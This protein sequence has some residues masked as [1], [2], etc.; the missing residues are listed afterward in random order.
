VAVHF[1]YRVRLRESRRDPLGLPD[2]SVAER[3]TGVICPRLSLVEAHLN[4]AEGQPS[5]GFE[6]TFGT[7]FGSISMDERP[8]D[9]EI[10]GIISELEVAGLLTV[11]TDAQSRETWTLTAIGTQVATQRAMSSARTTPQRPTRCWMP[12]KVTR[13]LCR[14]IPR[15]EERPAH[16]GTGLSGLYGH[17]TR[18][19][20]VTSG[21][22]WPSY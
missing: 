16:H 22:L 19:S 2:L 7:D 13:R 20:A 5:C 18:S 6:F 8:S 21:W 4:P 1:G 3:E 10:D 11:G 9:E 15:H 14:L 17:E 12:R